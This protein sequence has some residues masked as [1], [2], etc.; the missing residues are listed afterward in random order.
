MRNTTTVAPRNPIV[1]RPQGTL[2]APRNLIAYLP[3]GTIDKNETAYRRAVW[4]ALSILDPPNVHL[5]EMSFMSPEE[6]AKSDPF[7]KPPSQWD[8]VACPSSECPEAT[9]QVSREQVKSGPLSRFF[10]RFIGLPFAF[11][12]NRSKVESR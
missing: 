8:F 2:V 12:R 1:Y 9:P 6:F 4:E 3:N 7:R 10:H 11:L 5:F